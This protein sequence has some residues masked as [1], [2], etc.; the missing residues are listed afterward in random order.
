MRGSIP[1]AAALTTFRPVV[2]RCSDQALAASSNACSA[3]V[4]CS[5]IH[6]G[7]SPSSTFRFSSALRES[8]NAIC[9]SRNAA[10][11]S[12]DRSSCGTGASKTRGPRSRDGAS[13][14][15][16]PRCGRSRSPVRGGRSRSPPRGRSVA[17]GLRCVRPPR[18][19]RAGRRS[20][21][22]AAVRHARARDYLAG[23]RVRQLAE[24]APAASVGSC[25]SDGCCG[26]ESCGRGRPWPPRPPRRRRGRLPVGSLMR[27][28]VSH[29][30]LRASFSGLRTPRFA[31]LSYLRAVPTLTLR[32]RRICR[33]PGSSG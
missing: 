16:S 25:T 14:L 8:R 5:S 1:S 24:A 9:A 12:T 22:R 6:S 3:A 11:S 13:R 18:P 7:S 4:C 28:R 17:L 33:S 31:C 15:R 21:R 32:L 23:D 29:D 19:G 27:T 2:S 20:P 26:A 30:D 10:P